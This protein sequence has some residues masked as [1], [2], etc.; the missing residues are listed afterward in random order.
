MNRVWVHERLVKRTVGEKGAGEQ[1]LPAGE[2]VLPRQHQIVWIACLSVCAVVGLIVWLTHSLIPSAPRIDHGLGGYSLTPELEPQSLQPVGLPRRL[3]PPVDAVCY[4]HYVFDLPATR[5]DSRTPALFV[6]GS[7]GGLGVAV[8]GHWITPPSNLSAPVRRLMFDPQ[9]LEIP[10]ALSAEMRRIQVVVATPPNVYDW[11]APFY[12]GPIEELADAWRLSR[13]LSQDLLIVSNGIYLILILLALLSARVAAPD[14]LFIWFAL[15]AACAFLRNLFFVWVEPDYLLLMAGV[16]HTSTN[17]LAFASMAFV[18]TLVGVGRQ[19]TYGLLL[20]LTLPI[21]GVVFYLLEAL[22]QVGE[23]YANNLTQAVVCIVTVVT[24][25]YL[26]SYF[27]SPWTPAKAWVLASF[28]GSFLFTTHDIVVI[29]FMRQ[30]V[31]AQLSSLSPLLVVVAFCI[32]LAVRLGDAFKER[33]DKARELAEAVREREQDLYLAYAQLREAERKQ[34]LSDERARLMRDLHDGVGGQLASLV[35]SYRQGSS[36]ELTTKL[37]ES[38]ADLRA[39]IDSMDDE[40]GE[41]LRSMLLTLQQRISPWIDMHGLEQQW[42]GRAFTSD[43]QVDSHWRLNLARIVQE[44][45]MNIVRHAD[46]SSVQV[47]AD[48]SQGNLVLHLIDDGVGLTSLSQDKGRGLKN[49]QRRL[50]DMGGDVTLGDC[51]VS[52]TRLVFEIPIDC[53]QIDGEQT[54]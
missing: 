13:F 16:Y 2:T 4:G 47:R 45:V 38:L 32:V 19:R 3:C 31:P 41:D 20:L 28:V 39:V 46:A 11:L 30:N 53:Q 18:G 27:G 8:D 24:M 51:G 1:N 42:G 7:F 21:V 40:R 49:I 33:Q 35:I 37:E 52:G 22:P 5:A 36:P 17:L 54:A 48:L 26:F 34:T 9:L 29:G 50:L 12:I 23:R 25:K 15:L 6:P 14:P 10:A 43:V 44:G